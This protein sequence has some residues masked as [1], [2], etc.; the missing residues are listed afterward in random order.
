MSTT[1]PYGNR[2]R[3]SRQIGAAVI[4][5]LTLQGAT[6]LLW[7]GRAAERINQLEQRADAGQGVAERLASLEAHMVQ[8]RQSLDRIENKLDN[9]E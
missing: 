8:T 9:F 4:V 6:A 5:A 3:V 1:Q 7:A 2:W